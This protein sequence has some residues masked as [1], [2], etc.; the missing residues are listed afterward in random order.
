MNRLHVKY[1]TPVIEDFFFLFT[2]FTNFGNLAIV[3]IQVNK[4]LNAICQEKNTRDLPNI[5]R[6]ECQLM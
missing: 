5:K 3:D 4:Y 1:R 6:L 2:A